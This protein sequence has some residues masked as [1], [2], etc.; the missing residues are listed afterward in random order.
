MLCHARRIRVAHM[1]LSFSYPWVV[2][3]TVGNVTGPRPGMWDMLGRAKWYGA[4]DRPWF[5]NGTLIYHC[6][7]RDAWAK[8]KDLQQVEA[9]WLYVEALLKV[10]WYSALHNFF[11]LIVDH[12]YS[13]SI[14]IRLLHATL[15]ERLNL[16]AVATLLILF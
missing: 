15:L 7:Y 16:S 13:E 14:Q 12:R 10:C 1:L 2:V 5:R 3:A 6:T 11:V 4:F 9:K 8:H